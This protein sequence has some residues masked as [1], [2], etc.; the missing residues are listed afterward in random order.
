[1]EDST[2]KTE[3]IDREK[4]EVFIRYFSGKSFHRKEDALYHMSQF[5]APMFTTT[6][7]ADT[8]QCVKVTIQAS[9]ERVVVFYSPPSGD[10]DSDLEA[11]RALLSRYG[12]DTSQIIFPG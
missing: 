2:E 10:A 4:P 11:I 9:K 1:M 6:V 12:I 5:E 3:L 8:L 7:R